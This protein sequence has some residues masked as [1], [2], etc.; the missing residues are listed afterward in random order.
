MRTHNNRGVAHIILLAVLV[1][2]ALSVLARCDIDSAQANTANHLRE[3][4]DE[5]EP[6][7]CRY[8]NNPDRAYTLRSGL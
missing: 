6:N 2:V 4:T 7:P 5:M 3:H 1:L 8:G